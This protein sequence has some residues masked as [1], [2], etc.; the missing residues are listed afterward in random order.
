MDIFIPKNLSIG[1]VV[2]NI[3]IPSLSD[4]DFARIYALFL[5]QIGSH[6]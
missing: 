4:T 2:E 5:E 1:A 3:A 6:L